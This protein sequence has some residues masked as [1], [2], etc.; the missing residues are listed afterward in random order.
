MCS[1]LPAASPRE[2]LELLLGGH[3]G[4]AAPGRALPAPAPRPFSPGG[5]SLRAHCTG[6]D[7]ASPSTL[8]LR[9]LCIVLAPK[10]HTGEKGLPRVHRQQRALPPSGQAGSPGLVGGQERAHSTGW[11][12]A[13]ASPILPLGKWRQPRNSWKFGSIRRLPVRKSLTGERGERE[14]GPPNTSRRYCHGILVQGE[15]AK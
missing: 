12:S 6:Q 10:P 9:H 5:P 4:P 11:A 1:A 2:Q 14:P 15:N 3:A 8:H 13:P 7:L